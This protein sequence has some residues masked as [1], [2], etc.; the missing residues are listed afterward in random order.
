MK[1]IVRWSNLKSSHLAMETP[2]SQ[3][4]RKLTNRVVEMALH[5][6]LRY[7]L[8]I[9][10]PDANNRYVRDE[11]PSLKQ[12]TDRE[13]D[14]KE[15]SDMSGSSQFSG[16]HSALG[17]DDVGVDDDRRGMPQ[18]DGS[19]LDVGSSDE[20]FQSAEEEDISGSDEFGRTHQCTT[21]TTTV[22]WTMTMTVM[23]IMS[24]HSILFWEVQ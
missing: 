19:H 14:D 2:T 13:V 5:M 3:A 9:R 4:H 6:M 17:E 23:T 11:K 8:V 18:E 22:Y 12:S 15:H 1:S 21:R 10:V 7:T 24:N 20:G 16:S